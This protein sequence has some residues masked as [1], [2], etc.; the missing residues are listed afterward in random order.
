MLYP[1]SYERRR[2][3]HSVRHFG[4]GLPRQRPGELCGKVTGMATRLVH[5]VIDAH[6]PSRLAQFW[7]AGLGWEV[8]FDEPDEAGVWPAGFD[9]PGPS[10][11]P[12]VLDRK[13]VV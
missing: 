10:A 12:L 11:L 5:M 2:T 13:S 1:L 7:A 9:Y 6:D 8:G 4:V 3:S